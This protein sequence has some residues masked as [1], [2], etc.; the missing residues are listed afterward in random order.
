[1]LPLTGSKSS[2]E[3]TILIEA[4]RDAFQDLKNK[5]ENRGLKLE[6]VTKKYYLYVLICAILRYTILDKNIV[7]T[8][9]RAF[10]EEYEEA[11]EP[12]LFFQNLFDCN[13]AM[14]L[15]E[16]RVGSLG[17]IIEVI[18]SLNF[19]LTDKD[20]AISIT[21]DQMETVS[22]FLERILP[23]G[24]KNWFDKEG[25]RE[26]EK[27]SFDGVAAMIEAI[28]RD[29]F[30][31]LEVFQ[32]SAEICGYRNELLRRVRSLNES[33]SINYDDQKFYDDCYKS[34][35]PPVG[36]RAKPFVIGWVIFYFIMAAYG[37]Q[38]TMLIYSI[39]AAVGGFLLVR[40]IDKE[41][42]KRIAESETA[43]YR[44]AHLRQT[45][46]KME[47]E[48][49][50]RDFKSDLQ[51]VSYLLRILVPVGGIPENMWGHGSDLWN[52]IELRRADSLKEAINLYE[53]LEYRAQTQEMLNIQRDEQLRV[54]EQL[55][56]MRKNQERIMEAQD[57]LEFSQNLN[58]ALGIF[59][60]NNI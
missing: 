22:A 33:L 23:F 39:L 35:L 53:E 12:S 28:I 13:S 9:S 16:N 31:P 55:R 30:S 54:Q 40:K 24:R 56:E 43:P 29:A 14:D 25:N 1:M 51:D 10:Q 15:V 20:S 46:H 58:T 50:L 52:L 7:A 18:F 60:L 42:S 37:K 3:P 27:D 4:V 26:D 6:P 49:K 21:S 48:E 57:D 36:G 5:G 59:I 17:A 44:K 41:K 11:S 45:K 47:W 32:Y 8:L 19:Q 2:A 34:V 38:D